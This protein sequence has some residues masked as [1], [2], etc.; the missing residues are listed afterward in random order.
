MSTLLD[1]FCGSWLYMYDNISK[2]FTGLITVIL[3]YVTISLGK[4]YRFLIIQ[5]KNKVIV[6]SSCHLD[7]CVALLLSHWNMYHI[8]F[9]IL[10]WLCKTKNYSRDLL[11]CY[12]NWNP[13]LMKP[14]QKYMNENKVHTGMHIQ[15]WT[16]WP[17]ICIITL[18]N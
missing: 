8:S 1:K 4:K 16:F 14:K 17:I 10:K 18:R 3:T 13:Y 2:H 11:M 15:Q 6:T 5:H 9:Y 12:S 7:V